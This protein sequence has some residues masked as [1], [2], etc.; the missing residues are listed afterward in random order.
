VVIAY[1]LFAVIVKERTIDFA[2]KLRCHAFVW[3][4][5]TLL[6]LLPLTTSSYGNAG[7]WC[8]IKSEGEAA[9]DTQPFN[10]DTGVW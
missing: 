8:W 1:N 6:T 4:V 3:S 10:M 2:F 9:D 7:P 5:S